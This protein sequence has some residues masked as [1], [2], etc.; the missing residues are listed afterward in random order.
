[1]DANSYTIQGEPEVKPLLQTSEVFTQ[2]LP[3]SR[4]KNALALGACC[5][6]N[7]VLYCAFSILGPFFPIEVSSAS[8]LQPCM[9][10]RCTSQAALKG[11]SYTVIGSIVSASPLCVVLLSPFLGYYVS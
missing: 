8:L 9:H 11:V 4:V 1:M 5:F 7:F 10:A 3:P 6:L 2:R